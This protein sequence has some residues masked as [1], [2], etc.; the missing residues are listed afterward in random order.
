MV[1]M[2]VLF[3]S[4]H[5]AVVM[6]GAAQVVRRINRGLERRHSL[7]RIATTDNEEED[8]DDD[9]EEVDIEEEEDEEDEQQQ[10]VAAPRVL[11]PPPPSKQQGPEGAAPGSSPTELKEKAAP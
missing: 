11:A 3:R 4:K 10:Q 5:T 9:N 8:Q 6:E 1:V 2:V 7:L